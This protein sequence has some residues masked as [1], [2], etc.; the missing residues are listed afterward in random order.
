MGNLQKYH[1]SSCKCYLLFLDYNM[2]NEKETYIGKTI[3]DS[4]K[5]FKVRINQHISICKTGNF[6]L[7]YSGFIYFV[8]Q[9]NFPKFPMNQ[10]LIWKS[11]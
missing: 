6:T 4:V 2:H 7:R 10:F 3:D 1:S 9:S 11:C 8:V 5:N